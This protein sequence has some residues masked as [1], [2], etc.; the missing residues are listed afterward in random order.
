MW[1]VRP[2]SDIPPPELPA[3]W[4][5][6]IAGRTVQGR[7]IEL[8]VRAV[9]APRRRVLVIGGLHGNE[10][11]TPPAVRGLFN[12]TIA[13]DVEVWLV[14]VAN[15]DGS[16]AGLRCNANGVDLNRNFPWDWRPSDGGP[17]PLSEPETQALVAM[18]EHLRPDVVIW[19]HQPLGY[20]SAIGATSSA[21][22]R[23]WADATGIRVRPDVT[24]HG[25]GESWSAFVANV[26]SMLIELPGW[27][28]T[29]Q[30][31]A[32]TQAG[33]EAVVVALG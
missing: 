32:D 17:S 9:D 19:V 12:A 6:V 10:P 28:A 1:E 33:V 15:P 7:H 22:E 18:V 13:P 26:P 14:P 24:Q 4:T 23:A 16:A 30:L 2:P 31:V 27:V 21:L 11:V 5:P 25:G 8:F 3:G 29:P 20:V